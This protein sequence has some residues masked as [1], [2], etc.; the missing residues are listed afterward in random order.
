[1]IQ[2][3]L[4][5][6][7][8][9]KNHKRA[10]VDK[11]MPAGG[12][13][14]VVIAAVILMIA[15][16]GAVGWTCWSAISDSSNKYEA[17]AAKYK[18]VQ[19]QI[20]SK[21]K[22]ADEVRKFREVVSNQMDVLRT[23]DP[24][25][26]I[27]WSQKINML[28]SLIPSDVFIDEVRINEDVQMVETEASRKAIETWKKSNDQKKGAQPKQ[29]FRPVLRYHLTL[30]GLAMGEDHDAQNNNVMAFQRAL[31]EYQT[32]DAVGHAH[33][34]MDGFQQ[35]MQFEVIKGEVYE[36]VAVNKFV[37][38]LTTVPFGEE[39]AKPAPAPEKRVASAAK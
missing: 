9:S 1:M 2:I 36:G 33:R 21:M 3:N 11:P 19:G 20:D 27:L 5:D 39:K 17:V 6:S 22:T 29:V 23:L 4:L 32:T 18:K 37:F 24:P 13:S 12:V 7:A 38:K 30:S 25:D 34:F 16:N 35:E 26:R 15:L 14:F 10:V 31:N 8:Q 28:A